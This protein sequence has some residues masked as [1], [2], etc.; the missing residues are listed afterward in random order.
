MYA[1]GAISLLSERMIGLPKSMTKAQLKTFVPVSLASGFMYNTPLVAMMIPAVRDMSARTGLNGSK[2]FMGLSFL[3]LLGGSMTLI[4]TSVNLIIAAM[5]SEATAKGELSGMKSIGLFD[6]MWI[7]LPA[8]VAGVAFMI[9]VG[10]RL[11]PDRKKRGDAG[12]K[13]RLYRSEFQIEPGSN[14]DGKSLEQS[15][16]AKP[17]DCRLSPSSETAHYPSCQPARL[18]NRRPADFFIFGRRVARLMDNY[19]YGSGL[20]D[21]DVEQ[22]SRTPACR[23][24]PVGPSSCN[25]TPN[26]RTAASR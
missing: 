24:G 17:V 6:P 2:L 3:A 4:G 7:G 14:L 19:R 21:G 5:V 22:A 11:L 18:S 1:T 26:I 15:G 20:C 12:A 8:T 13:K 9:L 23:G 25:R 16:F 10:T